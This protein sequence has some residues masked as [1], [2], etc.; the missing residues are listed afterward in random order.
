MKPTVHLSLLLGFLCLVQCAPI[1]APQE[2]YDLQRMSYRQL[3]EDPRF[4]EPLQFSDID[5]PRLH[6]ALFYATNA[7][8]A[9]RGAAPLT[10][11]AL[12]EKAAWQYAGRMVK[13]DFMAHEDPYAAHLRTAE[14]R[15][16]AT[17]VTN[18]ILAENLATYFGIQYRRRERV[19]V[20]PGRR[21][22]FSRT[23]YGQPIPNHTYRSFAESV[24]A[25]WMSSSRH[26]ENLLAEEA[27]EL[28]CGAA[29]FRDENGFPKFKLVQVFQWYQPVRS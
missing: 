25:F 20:L 24:I 18:A 3:Y 10:Y 7:V 9:S 14:Q 6:A 13:K 19:Y 17:G 12:L 26:R 28:G 22:Q 8:R 5:Y 23:P 29:F 16:Q 21:G 1:K 15:A 27:L 4:Q 11:H 2:V